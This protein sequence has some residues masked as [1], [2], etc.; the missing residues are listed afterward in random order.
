MFWL[1]QKQALASIPLPFAICLAASNPVAGFRAMDF[2]GL[3]V[4]ATAIAGEMIADR[5]LR[6]FQIDPFNRGQLC[7]TGLWAWSRHPNYFFQWL[8][9]LAYPLF[10]IDTTGVYSWG[11]LALAA[12]ACMYW[13]LVNISGIPPLEEHMLATRGDAFRDYQS[14]TSA[15]FPA[16]P[17]GGPRRQNG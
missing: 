3:V 7:D 13:L 6:R 8:G 5:Q 9:W 11:W 1:L 17:N 15:F 4:L 10:A 12:P 14:R 2:L 16:P